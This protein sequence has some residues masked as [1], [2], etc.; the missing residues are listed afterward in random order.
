MVI[1]VIQYACRC[2]SPAV[3]AIAS[4]VLCGTYAHAQAGFTFK[5]EPRAIG[6]ADILG[7]AIW[8]APLGSIKLNGN[9]IPLRL[10]FTS[11]PRPPSLSSPLGRGWSIPF[12][13]SALIEEDQATLRWHRP[14]GRIFYFTRERGNQSSKPSKPTDPVEFISTE[15]AWRAVKDPRK[16]FVVI[17][18]V[19]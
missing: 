14:D 16:R 13:S 17:S 8:T 15:V 18:H 7:Y 12:F 2:L 6:S 4:L 3:T 9:A 19:T 11:D 1:R 5:H 10:D